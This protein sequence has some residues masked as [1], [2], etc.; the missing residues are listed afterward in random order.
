MRIISFF[1]SFFV[2]LERD[3]IIRLTRSPENCPL[4]VTSIAAE[5]AG[6]GSCCYH[7][8]QFHHRRTGR[9]RHAY[10]LSHR[11]CHWPLL[12]EN[13]FSFAVFFSAAVSASGALCALKLFNRH[14]RITIQAFHMLGFRVKF[15]CT[16]TKRAFIFY[17]IRHIF[18]S[19]FLIF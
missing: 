5:R 8:P 14:F 4:I 15:H 16:A 10:D 1:G 19:P 6:R 17:N 9:N 3:D 18:R 11:F 13:Q 7:L 12:R 2:Q